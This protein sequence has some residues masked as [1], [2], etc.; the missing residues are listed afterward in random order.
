MKKL[1]QIIIAAIAIVALL[2]GFS[3]CQKTDGPAESVGKKID[4][5]VEKAGQ[6][7]EK[8]GDKVEDATKK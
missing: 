8:A 7:V 6:Q 3:G 1:G 5:T 4:K 2:T